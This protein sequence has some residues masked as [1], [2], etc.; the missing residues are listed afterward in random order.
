MA[1]RSCAFASRVA[2]SVLG[3]IGSLLLLS[4]ASAHAVEPD[5]PRIE[6]DA[7]RG[8][9]KQEIEL[10]ADYFVGRGVQRNEQQAAYWY[11]KAANSG[12][13]RAQKQIGYFYQVGIGVTRDPV[14]AVQWYQR[15][16]AGGLTSAKVNLGVAYLWGIGV[17]KNPE[18]ATQLFREATDRGNGSAAAY[19]GDMYYFG[20]GAPV[21]TASARHWYRK[22]ALLHDSLAQFRYGGLLSIDATHKQNL[23][24]ASI[25]LRESGRQG[26]VPAQH[27]LGL[28]LANHPELCA[29]PG[30]T[31]DLLRS[32]SAAGTWKSSAVLGALFREG[33]GVP[34]DVSEAYYYFHLAQLQGG[35]EA[36]LAVAT[37]LSILSAQISAEREKA[38]DAKATEW[39]NNHPM[40]LEFVYK[41]GTNEKNFPAFALSS[42]NA[43][44]HAGRLIPNPSF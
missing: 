1:D 37:D 28:L 41:E 30:E 24:K 6:I 35:E 23:R 17:Q 19:L 22:G 44:M 12:D 14:R 27:A 42:P 21:D 38:L 25:L 9:V 39:M 13:P 5:I 2:A 11:E 31:I 26:Y 7:E 15:A 33:R 32:A 10:G 18:L 20:I 8:S 43:E 4:V 29:Q 16:A 36:R 34:A 40:S 3:S